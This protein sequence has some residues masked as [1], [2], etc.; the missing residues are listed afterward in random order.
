MSS[1]T[2]STTQPSPSSAS[3]ATL[4]KYKDC[5]KLDK[6]VVKATK[7]SSKDPTERANLQSSRQKLVGLQSSIIESDVTF[8][9]SK[10]LPEK[11]WRRSFYDRIAELRKNAAST[12]KRLKIG[13]GGKKVT[14][15]SSVNG[16]SDGNNT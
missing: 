8:A 5:E 14:P 2:Q 3:V 9:V 1:A 11:M 4:K 6:S 15:G 12:A 13:G 7:L 10:Q 16:M